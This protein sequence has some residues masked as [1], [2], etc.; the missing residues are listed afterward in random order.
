MHSDIKNKAESL[1]ISKSITVIIEIE[2]VI[3]FI[4]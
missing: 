3:L 4:K 2:N 1:K